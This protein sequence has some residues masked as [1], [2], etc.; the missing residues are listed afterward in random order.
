[1]KKITFRI[2]ATIIFAVLTLVFGVGGLFGII[3]AIEFFNIPVY[4][5]VPILA[6]LFL[7]CIYK[8]FF[9]GDKM[10]ETRQTVFRQ[11]KEEF[12]QLKND[13]YEHKMNISDYLRYL[14]AKE[15]K[16]KG[17]G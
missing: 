10:S 15:R 12:E 8:E 16:E 7:W 11:T 1:M 13:A 2:I 3:W 14:V 17:N 4:V 6:I 5:F 9:G